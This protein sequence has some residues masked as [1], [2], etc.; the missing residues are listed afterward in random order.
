MLNLNLEVN[1]KMQSLILCDKTKEN[2]KYFISFFI[3]ISAFY[4]LTITDFLYDSSSV[5]T[6]ELQAFKIGKEDIYILSALFI[7]IFLMAVWKRDWLKKKLK[8]IEE[9]DLTKNIF[10]F[11][12]VVLVGSVFETFKD[13]KIDVLYMVIVISIMTIVINGTLHAILYKK[14]KLKQIDENNKKLSLVSKIMDKNGFNQII[15]VNQLKEVEAAADI[16]IVFTED[17]STDYGG[18]NEKSNEGLMS[19]IVKNNLDLK[20]KYEYFLKN[21]EHNRNA[22]E[23]YYKYMNKE[24]KDLTTGKVSFYFIEPE[25]YCFFSEVYIYKNKIRTE[26]DSAVEWMPSLGKLG[27]PNDQYYVNLEGNQVLFLNEVILNLKAKYDVSKRLN[28]EL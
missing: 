25:D 13:K 26:P 16:I 21:N 7:I 20:K 22:V 6:E 14:D 11:V 24:D 19:S 27:D 28:C 4:L 15:N 9:N 1:L 5:V 3:I 12:T 10:V 8:K 23:D 17:L 18:K 2:I